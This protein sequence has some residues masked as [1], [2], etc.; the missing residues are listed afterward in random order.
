[1]LWVLYCSNIQLVRYVS[2]NYVRTYTSGTNKNY[3]YNFL[4]RLKVVFFSQTFPLELL[5]TQLP[6]K[7][8][9]LSSVVFFLL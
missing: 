9:V 2:L 3:C 6:K 8:D 1:M 4:D 7:E 5:F